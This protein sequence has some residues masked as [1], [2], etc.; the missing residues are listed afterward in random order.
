MTVDNGWLR[1]IITSHLKKVLTQ[2]TVERN[3]DNGGIYVK[4]PNGD[5]FRV[6]VSKVKPNGHTLGSNGSHSG[7]CGCLDDNE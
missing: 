2:S 4:A 7:D 5:M 3:Y 1:T 6:E